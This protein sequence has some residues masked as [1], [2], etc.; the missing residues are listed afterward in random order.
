M[1]MWMVDPMILCRQHLM[2]EH[3][4]THAF[5]GTIR[6]QKKLDGYIKNNSL[7]LKSILK[8]HDDLANEMLRRGYNHKSPLTEYPDTSYLPG[9]YHIIEV[10]KDEALDLL[11]SRCEA[12]LERF[13][14]IYYFQKEIID[15]TDC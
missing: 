7:E 12:C 10:N 1:R 15:D 8:R 14:H 5:I 6:K 2:G 13:H 4:E 11:L 3:N 9:C